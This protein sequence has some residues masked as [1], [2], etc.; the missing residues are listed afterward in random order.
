MLER[1]NE[2]GFG[3]QDPTWLLLQMEKDAG[4]E[5]VLLPIRVRFG[6]RV[7]PVVTVYDPQTIMRFT[8]IDRGCDR[9][10]AFFMSSDGLE[11]VMYTAGGKISPSVPSLLEDMVQH[12]AYLKSTLAPSIAA[13]RCDDDVSMNILINRPPEISTF[14]ANRTVPGRRRLRRLCDF[15]RFLDKGFTVRTA[16]SKAGLNYRKRDLTKAFTRLKEVGIM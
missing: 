3:D 5:P 13:L 1:L 15:A 16:A 6:K 14:C 2:Q 9:Y 7:L 12:P 10:D 4:M 8:M 11:K